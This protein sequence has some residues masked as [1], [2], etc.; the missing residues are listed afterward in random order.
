MIPECHELKV[1]MGKSLFPFMA[2]VAFSVQCFIVREDVVHSFSFSLN[3][4]LS[5]VLDRNLL[6]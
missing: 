3:R 2:I 5:S 1:F 6:A 4:S